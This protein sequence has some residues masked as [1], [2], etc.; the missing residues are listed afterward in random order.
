V[1][2]WAVIL[3]AGSLGSIAGGIA[4]LHMRPRHPLVTSM[5][6]SMIIAAELLLLGLAVPV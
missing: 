6:G 3:I 1:V 4:G 2:L 5:I